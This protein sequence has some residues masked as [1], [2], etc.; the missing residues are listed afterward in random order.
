MWVVKGVHVEW[1]EDGEITCCFSEVSYSNLVLLSYTTLQNTTTL[2][3]R[4]CWL[5]FS[6]STR[7][8]TVLLAFIWGPLP[9]TELGNWDDVR[10]ERCCFDRAILIYFLS[11]FSLARR[12]HR[13]LPAATYVCLQITT[14]DVIHV[15]MW[16][17]VFHH[18]AV[19]KGYFIIQE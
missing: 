9:W 8:R 18:H 4:A 5:S 15:C 10:A 3:L 12:D 16:C 13:P 17:E 6:L 19:S 1:R 14:T 7:K 2:L 11:F